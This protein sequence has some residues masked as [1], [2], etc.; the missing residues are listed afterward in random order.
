MLSQAP[1]R[2]QSTLPVWGAT[3][4][5]ADDARRHAISIHA[6][7][8]GSDR[9]RNVEGCQPGYF[10]PRSPCGERH[11]SRTHPREACRFQSTLPV[12]GATHLSDNKLRRMKFQSTLPVW[13]ATCP[14]CGASSPAWRFQ[15]TLP[16]GGATAD[17]PRRNAAV[18]PFQSTL[19]VW[20]ATHHAG[21]SPLVVVISIHAPRVGSDR[22][23]G[24]AAR[25][26]GLSIH[27]PRVGSDMTAD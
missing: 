13:G 27:A 5:G 25:H 24:P 7:R 19:P 21:V 6:P 9:L 4:R 15:S 3:G 11:T 26:H 8:V 20:G 1:L 2:F 17:D 22:A 10:N 12:W 23:H 16:V 14:A 18:L